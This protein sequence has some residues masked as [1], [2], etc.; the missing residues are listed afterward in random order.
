MVWP[1]VLPTAA[2]TSTPSILVRISA[3]EVARISSIS[4]RGTTL[5]EAGAWVMRCSKPEA[6]TTTSSILVALWVWS[7]T[8][9]SAIAV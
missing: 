5:I 8:T 3:I 7:R 9:S 6:V 1:P 2:P 4:L